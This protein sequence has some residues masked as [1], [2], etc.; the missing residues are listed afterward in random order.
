MLQ[1]KYECPDCKSKRLELY[2]DDEYVYIKCVECGAT[3]TK[4][5]KRKNVKEIDDR[6]K[7]AR[8]NGIIS[9]LVFLLIVAVVSALVA[10]FVMENINRNNIEKATSSAGAVID[11]IESIEYETPT[12]TY[13]AMKGG[14]FNF[15]FRTLENKEYATDYK[16]RIYRLSKKKKEDEYVLLLVIDNDYDKI[17]RCAES[18]R[19][20]VVSILEREKDDE[21]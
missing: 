2:G 14:D 6:K 8:K 12:V 21:L 16:E 11:A 18:Y 5:E 20:A 17:K 15:L 13:I 19:R 7:A 10:R 9:V 1:K 4:I 3:I